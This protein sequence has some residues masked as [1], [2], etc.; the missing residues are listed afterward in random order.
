MCF[1]HDMHYKL[2][3]F[4][5]KWEREASAE[6]VYSIS[7]QI[8]ETQGIIGKYYE[9]LIRISFIFFLIIILYPLY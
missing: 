1:S 8:L 2:K 7:Y 4:M 3:D 5:I 9:D 6:V